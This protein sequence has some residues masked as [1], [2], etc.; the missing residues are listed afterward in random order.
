MGKLT[1][2]LFAAAMVLATSALGGAAQ[3]RD[4]IKCDS[5]GVCYG[6]T[7]ARAILP[8]PGAFAGTSRRRRMLLLPL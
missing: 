8:L 1:A 4:V 2:A 6:A 5:V 7:G 3:A